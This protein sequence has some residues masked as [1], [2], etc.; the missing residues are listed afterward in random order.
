MGMPPNPQQATANKITPVMITAMFLFFPL[1]AGVL[2]YMVVA[3]IFQAVQTWLLTRESLPENLQAILDK[4][5][6]QQTVTASAGGGDRLPF[7]PNKGK[8]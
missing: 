3:N 4:Q 2:L 8:K 7:E 6:S 5:I 1:P